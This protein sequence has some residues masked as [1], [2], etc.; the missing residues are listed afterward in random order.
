MLRISLEQ[1]CEVLRD[2]YECNVP[3]VNLWQMFISILLAF[4]K[5]VPTG[6]GIIGK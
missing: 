1:I 4:D 6:S 5:F 2:Q 3:N